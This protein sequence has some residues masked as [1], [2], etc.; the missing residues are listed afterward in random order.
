MGRGALPGVPRPGRC[1]AQAVALEHLRRDVS[2]ALVDV[3]LAQ[4][5]ARELIAPLEASVADDPLDERHWTQLVLAHYRSGDQAA[6]L[7]TYRRARRVLTEELGVEPGAA[8]RRLHRDVLNHAD[9]LTLD[10][11]ALPAVGVGDGSEPR[12]ATVCPFKGLAPYAEDDAG[13]LIGRDRPLA[14]A[15]AMLGSEGV[16]ALTGPSGNGKT[17]LVLAGLVPAVRG[18]AIPGSERWQVALMTPGGRPAGSAE[19]RGR[20]RAAG[21]NAQDRAANQRASGRTTGVRPVARLLVVDQ[22]EELFTLCPDPRNGGLS[23]TPCSRG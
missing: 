5:A 6:A 10:S 20:A 1:A 9:T 8:L 16:V 12:A 15:L 2:D 17:S 22:F 21:T 4:G 7:Q 13:Q 23:S 11:Y 18:G 19:R 3:G 14:K